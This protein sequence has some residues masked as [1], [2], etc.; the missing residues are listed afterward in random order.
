MHQ[1]TQLRRF[2]NSGSALQ[3]TVSKPTSP[4]QISAISYLGTAQHQEEQRHSEMEIWELYDIIRK[5]HLRTTLND[6]LFPGTL[7]THIRQ[8]KQKPKSSPAPQFSFILLTWNEKHSQD[9]NYFAPFPN[10]HDF[11]SP[12]MIYNIWGFK[13]M[14]P[15]LL[16]IIKTPIC[17]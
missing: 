1:C 2:K 14:K 5:F 16:E 7:K 9:R 4:I 11:F 10:I 15:S 17:C 12:Y 8:I 6:I 13:S 3:K